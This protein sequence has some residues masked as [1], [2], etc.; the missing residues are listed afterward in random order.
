MRTFSLL[1]VF[2]A[3]AL[4]AQF[5]I[6]VSRGPLDPVTAGIIFFGFLACLVPALYLLKPFER[7]EQRRERE[8]KERQKEPPEDHPG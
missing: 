5:V 6:Y 4:L 8:K 7:P 1:F 3:L 2:I